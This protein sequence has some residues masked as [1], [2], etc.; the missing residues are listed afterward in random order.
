MFSIAAPRERSPH[1][2][3]LR[4]FFLFGAPLLVLALGHML[5]NLVLT[6]P[7][8]AADMIAADIAVT[9]DT[10]ASLTGAYHFSFA[11]G[12]IP[13]GVALD[14]YGVRSVSLTL[15]AIVIAGAVLARCLVPAFGRLDR[16]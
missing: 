5:S 11:L 7:G 1:A 6:L 16:D 8:I 13:V 2:N 3:A 4:T 15:F 14:R 10:L 12:Q 9:P